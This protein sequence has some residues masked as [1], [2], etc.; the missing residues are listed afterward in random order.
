MS[1]PVYDELKPFEIAMTEIHSEVESIADAKDGR[2]RALTFSPIVPDNAPTVLTFENI[3][4]TTKS[5]IPVT[6]L[7]GISGQITG[8]YHQSTFHILAFNFS[9]IIGFYAIMGSS[10]SGKTTLLSTLSLRLDTRQMNVEGDFRL[11]GRQYTKSILKSMSAYVMQ[12]DILHAELTVAETLS[13][14]AELRLPANF[15][16]KERIARVEEVINLMGIAEVKDVIIGD[17]RRKGKFLISSF[18]VVN[19]ESQ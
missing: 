4:V 7:H 12:D 18:I 13:Y 1:K 9:L 3:T 5:D 2:T 17:S 19:Y 14:A 11:N 16:S 10:G 8:G 6:L 15:I